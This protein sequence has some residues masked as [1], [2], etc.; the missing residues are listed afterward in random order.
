MFRL[1]VL[2]FNMLMPAVLTFK[3]LNI[4]ECEEFRELLLAVGGD[5]RESMIPHHTKLRELVIQHWKE[6]FQSLKRDLAVGIPLAHL[7]ILSDIFPRPR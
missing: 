1:P 5:L 6:C 4:M 2:T 3:S 7:V